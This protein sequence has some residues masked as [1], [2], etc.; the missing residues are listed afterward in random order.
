MSRFDTAARSINEVSSASW[1]ER[2]HCARSAFVQRE[3]DFSAFEL[4]KALG[5][6]IWNG[7]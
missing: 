5:S 7:L 2:H 1:N 4:T 3:L 6:E